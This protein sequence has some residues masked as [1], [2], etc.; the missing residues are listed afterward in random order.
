LWVFSGI[1]PPGLLP[2]NFQSDKT[3]V[4]DFVENASRILETACA[5]GA[6]GD[7]TILVRRDGSIEMTT[8]SQWALAAMEAHYG[9]RAV[10][11]VI[12]DGVRV[13]VE[14]RSGGAACVLERGT[15]P[16]KAIRVLASGPK[17]LMVPS[18][19]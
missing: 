10:Y 8:D 2:C 16:G 15:S 19:T 17:Y 13:R 1:T 18:Y 4:W 6:S 12:R 9:A 5:P 7:M 14:G 11:R 3:S